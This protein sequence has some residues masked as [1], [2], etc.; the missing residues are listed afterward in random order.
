[1]KL[2]KPNMLIDS[3]IIIDE[4]KYVVIIYKVNRER[5][6]EEGEDVYPNMPRRGKELFEI[7]H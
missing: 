4:G 5:D 7:V 3:S 6:L 2:L 1:M